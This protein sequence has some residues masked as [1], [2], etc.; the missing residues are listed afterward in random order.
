MG[1][2]R[3]KPNYGVAPASFAGILIGIQ[4]DFW[5]PLA[6]APV[7]ARDPQLLQSQDTYWLFRLGHV[8][9]GTSRAQAQA[10]LSVLS[11]SL[12]L[13]V[14]NSNMA[15]DAAIFPVQLVPG[16]YRGYVAAFTGFLMVVVG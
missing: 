3:T 11:H 12:E 16:P 14:T 2:K 13:G 15:F 5:T 8:K 7:L 1:K 4:P 9:P 10:D 6:M